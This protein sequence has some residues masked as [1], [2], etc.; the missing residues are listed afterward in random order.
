MQ[1]TIQL[2]LQELFDLLDNW[3]VVAKRYDASATVQHLTRVVT[4]EIEGEESVGMWASLLL[5]S[6][7]SLL[8]FLKK[9]TGPQFKVL[10]SQELLVGLTSTSGTCEGQRS[11]ARCSSEAC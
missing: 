7:T 1:T 10:E 2:H 6:E 5:G 3:A 8:V 11:F 4:Q 9:T